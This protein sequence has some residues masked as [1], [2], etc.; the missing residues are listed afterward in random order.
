MRYL[1]GID[2]GGGASKA[3]LLSEEG[4]IVAES[5]AEYP[6]LYPENGA[7]EQAPEDWW[8]ALRENVTKL[9]S[10][11]GVSATSIA[12]VAL[13]SATHT[14]VL[15]DAAFQPLRPAIH[16]TDSRSRKMAEQLKAMFT[17]KGYSFFIKSVILAKIWRFLLCRFKLGTSYKP[18]FLKGGKINKKW[19]SAK[20]RIG[21][22]WRIA[23]VGHTKRKH[24]PIRKAT[25][26]KKVYK[27]LRLFAKRS[28]G[29][30]TGQGR[31]VH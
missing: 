22:I 6:T 11:S 20:R 4:V 26:C 16:W 23:I 7:C 5:T 31:Y 27:F 18:F 9:L 24:L 3:T 30:F 12:C 2:F 13:D 1:L 15:C 14:A 29:I 17:E 8:K 25:V 10:T 19:I 28:Y 21:F